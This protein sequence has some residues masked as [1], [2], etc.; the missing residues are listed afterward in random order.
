MAKYGTLGELDEEVQTKRKELEA[1]A[2]EMEIRSQELDAA[3][4]RLEGLQKETV[5]VEKALATY[6]RLEA[7]GF[8]E[9]AL[10]EMAKVAEKYGGPRKVLAGV[11][12]FGDLSEIKAASEEM[13]GKLQQQKA[14][15]K[16]VEDK[17]SHLK[18]AI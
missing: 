1:L 16:D 12:S 4:E 3:G 5:A 2:A 13:H 7:I 11:N 18:S 6:R 17:H 9:K 14:M 10:E 8:D 15:L